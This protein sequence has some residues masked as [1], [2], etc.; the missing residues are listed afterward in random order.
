MYW[1]RTELELK[2]TP[3]LLTSIVTFPG[4]ALLI[5]HKTCEADIHSI[6]DLF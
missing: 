5:K 6:R 3:L 4:V 1:T 2:S